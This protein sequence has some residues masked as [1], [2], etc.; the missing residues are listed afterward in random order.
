VAQAET[1]LNAGRFMEAIDRFRDLKAA[2]LQ[3]ADRVGPSDRQRVLDGLRLALRRLAAVLIENESPAEAE[4]LLLESLELAPDDIDTILN[5]ARL[6][7][8]LERPERAEPYLE[9]AIQAHP[10]QPEAYRL[11]G[12]IYVGTDRIDEAR[13]L[14]RRAIDSAPDSAVML[15]MLER[16]SGLDPSDP[17]PL[18]ELG[19]AQAR[20]GNRDEAARAFRQALAQKPNDPY[21]RRRLGALLLQTG[22]KDEGVKLLED[23]PGLNDDIEA[24]AE[25]AHHYTSLPEASQALP[26]LR[27]LREIDLSLQEMDPVLRRSTLRQRGLQS[28]QVDAV[29]APIRMRMLQ[30][31]A[32]IEALAGSPEDAAAAL[33]EALIYGGETIGQSAVETAT[34]LAAEFQ[35]RGN[36]AQAAR[37][38]AET[39]RLGGSL[40]RVRQEKDTYEDFLRRFRFRPQ[41][42]LAEGGMARVYRGTDTHTGRLVA[43]KRMHDRFCMDAQ[44]VAYFYREVRALEELSRPYPHANIV[45]FIASGMTESR[46]IFAMELVDGPSLRDV[47]DRGEV[48]SLDRLCAIIGGIC[49]G[50]DRAHNSVRHIIHR[51]LKPENVLMADATTP[52]LTDFGICR[53]SSLFSASRRYYGNTR[54]FVGTSLYSAPEQYPDPY[55][56]QIPT[57][58]SR[59][60]LYSLGC[61]LY[62]ALTTQ[63]PFVSADPGLIGLMHQRRP[64]PGSDAAQPLLPPSERN[65]LSMQ[66]FTAEQRA[67]L[68]AIVM[69]LLDV[70]PSRRHASARSLAAD[71]EKL[72]TTDAVVR[73]S[74]EDAP[75][76]P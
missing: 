10:D 33:Q 58:D 74:S 40:E 60:D 11:L 52:K 34:S 66:Q 71:L 72:R 16:I 55:S 17:A 63:P 35:R 62:E 51:D 25:L 27:R 70:K 32:A 2:L 48:W 67:G 53:V 50:L 47:M 37:W 38:A 31:Y 44:A 23:A 41:D 1:L 6:Q 28:D 30:D 36:T 75:V 43:V 20:E 8:M 56:G 13:G 21:S 18:V 19:R 3:A 4:E 39:T 59:A 45:E 12:D 14:Y 22:H 73:S 5:L 26:L 29:Y 54:S 42:L 49:A 24:L 76:S 68:D 15:E 46:F 61:I 7:L 9:Q 64:L 69:K 57:V 65:P